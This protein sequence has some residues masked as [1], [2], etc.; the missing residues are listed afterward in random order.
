[1]RKA[2]ITFKKLVK[3]LEIDK[4]API[5]YQSPEELNKDNYI[6]F[7]YLGNAERQALISKTH[8]KK[9]EYDN[10]DIGVYLP[11]LT[12]RECYELEQNRNPLSISTTIQEISFKMDV[13]I[14]EYCI[15]W[16]VYCILH[17]VGHWLDFKNSGKSA[18]EFS[19]IEK[20]YREDLEK[21]R[22]MIYQIPDNHPQKRILMENFNQKYSEIPSE[23]KANEYAF[24]NIKKSIKVFREKMGYTEDDVIQGRIDFE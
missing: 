15:V 3:I 5:H 14:K 2:K 9:I 1:M 7:R 11:D 24:A 10:S 18:Y 21:E 13:L 23:K 22:R 17:E 12:I 19:I 6:F 8:D 4:I 20:G 16:A